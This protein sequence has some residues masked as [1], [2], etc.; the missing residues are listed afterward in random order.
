MIANYHTHHTL[1]GHATGVSKRYVDAAIELGL[2]TLGFADHVP[3]EFPNG[4]ISSYRMYPDEA[5]IYTQD[6]LRLK[7]EYEGKIE[8]LLGYEA[9]YF[10][11]IFDKMLK[12]IRQYPCDYLILGQHYTNNEYDGFYSGFRTSDRRILSRYTDQVIEALQTELFS[13][14]V[15]PDLLNFYGDDEFYKNEAYRLCE[16]AK[17]HDVPIEL[18]L[19]GLTTNRAYPKALFWEV[20]SKVGNDTIIGLDAHSPHAF[21]HN[22]VNQ[23]VEYLK[24]FGITPIEKLKLKKVK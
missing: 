17:K 21:T 7:E 20:A 12:N 18:N 23:G 24:N 11:E 22:A 2:K 5:R 6:I 13:C 19:L 8:I 3:Y 15:H 14:I 10:P 1:C 4:Y 9:E 16:A